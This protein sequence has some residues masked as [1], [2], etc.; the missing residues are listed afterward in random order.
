MQPQCNDWFSAKK[1]EG[2]IGLPKSS[3]AISRKARLEQ[4]VFRQ[5]HGVRGVAYEFHIS[6]LPKETQAALLLRQGEIETSMGRFEIARPTLEAHDYDREALWS[7][8]DNA[9]DSQR[10]L[11]EKWLPAVQAADEMLNQGISTK[12][13]FAT[14]AGHYQVSA[15]TLRDKYYQVQKFAKPDWAAALVDGRGAS[16]RNV[17]KSEF[18]EDA[19]Q[20]LIADYLRPEKPAFRKCYERLELA[21][22]EHG[23]S[24]PSRATAFRRIQQLNEAMVVACREGEHALMHLIPA[25]QRT[26]E[27]LDAMQWINGDGYLH[28]VF[29]RWFNGDVI[30]P[31]TWFWQD[32]KTRK[33]LGW[34]C[35]VSENIDSI[36]LSFMDVVTRY[37]IPEDFHITIDNTRGAANKW[38]TGGAP[39]RYRFKVKED[40]PKG[41]FLLMGAKM[42][43]TSVVAGKGWGQAKPVE[44]AFG[45]GGLEEYVDKHPALA[46]AYTGPNP[47]AKPDNYG[48]RAVDAELFLKTLAEGVAMF[49]ARTGRETEMC[50]GKLSFD[51]VFEREYARTIV[52]KPTEEQKRMLLLPAEAVNVSRK[53]EFALKVGGSLKG[54]KNVYYN[55]ALM[56]AGVKKVVV[57]FDPQQLHSTVY[58]YTLDGRFI[59]EAECLSPVAFNDAA[60]GREYRRRQKQLK[61]ATKA[62]IKAQ[63]QM[64]ALEVAELLPQIAEPEAPES[65]IVGI[66]RPSGNMERV[67]NQ[68]RDDE[69][70]TERD[71]YLN[72]SLDIL[73]QNRRKKAI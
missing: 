64:D 31:K 37:G 50:G 8:W 53:G 18:D 33:I 66:F 68:E 47:Q 7:K 51:D 56:N 48:D 40:D 54:A 24:I 59:C 65:R 62:A 46:G 45:V 30:R 13:A 1:L 55:M 72:H 25:Q 34:R 12:T 15:S 6:S 29:V 5:I 43:W 19:W 69:Y 23:W 28:N 52:R 71:E 26:V 3:S 2:L 63:K 44:R 67:K 4:W 41:L 49:N 27:H 36:R 38:L 21:A 70:E 10:R 11:A 57:R 73:E 17:H 32:V 60:A 58:C 35:D 39:N 42:H 20:F 61:S 22:R 14:V 9:S 16:R